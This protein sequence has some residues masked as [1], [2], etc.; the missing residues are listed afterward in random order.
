ML[1][2]KELGAMKYFYDVANGLKTM[3]FVSK[4]VCFRYYF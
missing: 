2:M 3:F 1:H 4:E